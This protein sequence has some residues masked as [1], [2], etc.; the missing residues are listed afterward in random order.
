MKMMTEY[1]AETRTLLDPLQ[2]DLLIQHVTS[3][4]VNLAVLEMTPSS[5]Q[6]SQKIRKT[7]HTALRVSTQIN[8]MENAHK[9]LD[10]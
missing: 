5:L 1:N 3:L 9:P 4:P 10:S 6:I 7:R 8:T 2:Y